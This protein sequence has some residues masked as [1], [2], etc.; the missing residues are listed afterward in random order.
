MVEPKLCCVIQLFLRGCMSAA[1]GQTSDAN[2]TM[3]PHPL[4]PSANVHPL[5]RAS[6]ALLLLACVG[7]CMAAP[8][9]E[10][11]WGRS[12]S[13]SRGAATVFAE[14]VFTERSIGSTRF[15]WAPDLSAG[16]IDGRA[17]LSRRHHHRHRYSTTDSIWLV[18][19]GAR[20]RYGSRGDWYH[21][22]FF[23]F[24]PA[25]HAGRTRALSSAYEFVSTLGWQAQRFS[26][27][28]RHVSNGSLHE[29]NCGE[30]MVLLGVRIGP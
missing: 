6:L 12:Y 15:T 3:K 29:P 5:I 24:Q 21:H 28:V 19:A 1:H 23:S 16:W 9:I 27:Q 14:G 10:L 8:R 20:L 11:Q 17:S 7:A 22:L 30:T 13:S 26:I 25:L 18:A 2:T 4:L